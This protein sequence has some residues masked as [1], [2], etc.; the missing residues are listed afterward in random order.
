MNIRRESQAERYDIIVVG[1]GMGG[2]TAAALLAKAGKKVLVV[3]R[4]DRPGGYAHAFQRKQ[5]HF[6]ATTHFIGEC[7]PNGFI[8][9]LLRYLGVRELCDFVRVD[10][11]YTAIYPGFRLQ[12]PLGTE[13]FLQAHLEHFPAEAAGLRHLLEVCS[14]LFHEMQTFPTDLSLW[15]MLRM[16]R[17]FPTLFK[18]RN[19]TLG[20]VMDEYL[21]DPRLKAAFASMWPALVLEP[22]RLSILPWSMVLMGALEDGMFYS[23]GSFQRLPNAFVEALQRDGG[24]LLLRS[25]VRRILVHDQQVQG[26]VLENGQQIAAPVVISNAD[27]TETIEELVG[28]EHFPSAYV[29]HIHQMKPSL[30]GFVAYLAT[31]LDLRQFALSHETIVY[32]SWD[33]EETYHTILAGKPG[34]LLLTIPTLIDPSLAPPGEHLVIVLTLIPYDLGVS[35]RQ[36][37]AEYLELLTNA[38]EPVIPGLHAHLTFAEG[39]SPRTLERYTLNLTGAIY[40]WELSPEQVGRKRHVEHQTPIEGLLLS[41]HWT[42]PGGG[43]NAVVLSGM[44]TAQLLLGNATIGDFLQ[45]PPQPPG[46]P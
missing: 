44:Q 36:E 18:Y 23:R 6:D 31:D 33:H 37:K 14:S 25:Q 35:W 16:P 43:V 10:P 12:A 24:E 27:V 8:D 19:A 11:F 4:H 34:V 26:V 20:Q 5:Y 21:V 38:V 22:S 7:Q 32:P 13:A 3:E 41:G 30:S 40:G 42:Q 17:Q 15:E 1:S 46:S 28:V 45:A 39:G 2:L 9:D 29:S